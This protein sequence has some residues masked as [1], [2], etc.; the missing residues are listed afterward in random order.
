[1]ENDLEKKLIIICGPTAVG[2]TKI[3]I[4]LANHLK[5]EIV[6]A[7]S[8]QIYREM[9]IGTAVPS[10]DEL[11]SAKHHFIHTHTIHKYYSSGKYELEALDLIENTLFK[12]Y[13]IVIVVGGSGL[14]IDALVKG[15]E[16]LPSA[17]IELRNELTQTYEK[18]GI[19]VLRMMLKKLDPVYHAKVDLQNHQR[20]LKAL[21]VCLCTG[22]PYSSMISGKNKQRNFKIIPI[23][24]NIDREELHARI[25][26]RVDEMMALGLLD[27]VNMLFEFKGLTALKTVGYQELFEYFDGKHSL[28]TAIEL[29]K[30]NTRRYAR[31]QIS[32]FNRTQNLPWFSNSTIDPIIKYIDSPI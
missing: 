28:D 23:G 11:L 18:Q 15:I 8:R 27:E 25:N 9:S 1:M 3:A 20:I 30:R 21:E 7:D 32:W 2:K 29:I 6:S 22:K 14:Y 4:E 26:K 16:Q 12:K 19:E 24:I 17:D 13:E 10:P 5:A 31:R